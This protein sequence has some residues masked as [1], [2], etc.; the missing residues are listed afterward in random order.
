[1]FSNKYEIVGKIFIISTMFPIGGI[2]YFNEL[3]SCSVLGMSC[4]TF[5]YQS[6]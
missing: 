4:F 1:M 6:E 3:E 5:G 2:C